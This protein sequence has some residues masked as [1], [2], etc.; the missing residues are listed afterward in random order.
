[1]F[2]N[3]ENKQAIQSFWEILHEFDEK[4]R[5]KFLFFVTSLKRPPI[6]VKIYFLIF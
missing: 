6:G 3:N 5:E 4:E 1:L 2:E